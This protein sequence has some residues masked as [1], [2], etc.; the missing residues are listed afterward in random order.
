MNEDKLPWP[1]VRKAD[2]QKVPVFAAVKRQDWP[3]V[4]I[5]DKWGKVIYNECGGG[6]KDIALHTEALKKLNDSGA[7]R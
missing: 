5:T 3:Q 2:W 4:L 6:P 1:V 7:A